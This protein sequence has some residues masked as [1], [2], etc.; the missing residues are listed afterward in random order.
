MTTKKETAVGA[1]KFSKEQLLAA[2]IFANRKDALGAVIQDGEELTIDEAKAR[3]E[4]L[5][6]GKVK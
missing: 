2:A 1:M 3:L 4:G 5:M 6:K